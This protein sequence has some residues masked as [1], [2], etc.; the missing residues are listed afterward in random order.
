MDIYEEIT[1]LRKEGRACAMATIVR[2]FG[3]SPRKE[4]TKM[5]VRDD[6]STSGT[7]GGGAAE[8]EVI[9]LS[10]TAMA[11]GSVRTVPFNLAGKDGAAACGGRLQVLIEPIL[12]DPHLVIVG[13]GH[14][15]K[16][17][18]SVASFAGFRVTVVD[19]RSEYADPKA[20]PGVDRVVLNEFTDPFR[21]IPV[22]PQTYVLIA[23]R[24]HDH[25]LDA[26]RSALS[27]EA[28]YIG[29]VGSAQKRTQFLSALAREGYSEADVARIV[30]PVGLPIGSVTPEE[31]AI[32]IAAQMIQ[33]RRKDAI[34]GIGLTACGGKV[35]EDGEAQAGS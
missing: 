5:L 11:D 16:A 28:C 15:G 31:I 6:G 21:G 25:D 30:T 22:N 29:L 12:P 19:D 33:K 4:G 14:I 32:S 27:T 3:S 23:T 9:A 26:V 34:S 7:I 18:C 1:R 8:R 10:L 35:K 13:A 24:G 17:L 20:V 2:T